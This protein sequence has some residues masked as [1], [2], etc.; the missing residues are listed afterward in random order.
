D[1]LPVDAERRER[2]AVEASNYVVLHSPGILRLNRFLTTLRRAIW[3][4]R[5]VVFRLDLQ[6]VGIDLTVLAAPTCA[7]RF[8]SRPIGMNRPVHSA[9]IGI[10]FID[11]D[12]QR[13][14]RVVVITQ[15]THSQGGRLSA[16]PGAIIETLE[17][18]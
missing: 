17:P 13:G 3:P 9:R 4:E 1:L 14:L 12:V 5:T 7:Y 15:I 8:I 10:E 6:D 2:V 11:T 18:P 16:E